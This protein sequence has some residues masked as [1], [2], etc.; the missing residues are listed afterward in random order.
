MKSEKLDELEVHLNLQEHIAGTSH[1]AMIPIAN[2]KSLVAAAR[3]RNELV[4]ERDVLK[5]QIQDFEK[6]GDMT[7]QHLISE[8]KKEERQVELADEEIDALT[9]QVARLREALIDAKAG[10]EHGV[11]EHQR[12]YKL[13]KIDKALTATPANSLTKLRK[14]IEKS[15]I[16]DLMQP[17]AITDL[18]EYRNGVL[19]EAAKEAEK[20]KTPGGYKMADAIRTMRTGQ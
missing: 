3:E 12:I 5:E 7:T 18:T 9:A 4:A 16:E 19:E 10:I 2:V 6:Y 14:E 11:T 20:L 15:I 8:I 1:S 13:N 17:D